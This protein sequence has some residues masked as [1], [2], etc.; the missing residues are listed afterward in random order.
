MSGPS[1]WQFFWASFNR[2]SR[3]GRSQ[4]PSTLLFSSRLELNGRNVKLAEQS[5]LLPPDATPIRLDESFRQCKKNPGLTGRDFPSFPR[6][7]AAR[8]QDSR[9]QHSLAP[10]TRHPGRN[11]QK[12]RN[13]DCCCSGRH[14][15]CSSTGLETMRWSHWARNSTSSRRPQRSRSNHSRSGGRPANLKSRSVRAI[16]SDPPVGGLHLT[17]SHGLTAKMVGQH[18]PFSICWDMPTAWTETSGIVHSVPVVKTAVKFEK[19]S[20]LYTATAPDDVF[21]HSLSPRFE[22]IASPFS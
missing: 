14:S 22:G 11:E 2:R 7:F 19:A 18:R 17:T 9:I 1:S 16:A 12:S 3:K 6:A 13:V 8:G 20:S 4:T 15:R 21:A 10:L 5:N